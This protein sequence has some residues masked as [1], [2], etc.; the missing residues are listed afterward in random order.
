MYLRIYVETMEGQC[1]PLHS[2]FC[3]VSLHYSPE[4]HN[5]GRGLHSALPH[6]GPFQNVFSW[7]DFL[8]HASL[9]LHLDFGCLPQMFILAYH[10]I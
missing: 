5:G 7:E 6:R 9:Q 8:Y 4:W 2:C 3:F 1:I 10:Y